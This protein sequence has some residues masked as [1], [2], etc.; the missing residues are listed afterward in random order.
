MATTGRARKMASTARRSSPSSRR[1]LRVSRAPGRVRSLSPPG[2]TL[3]QSGLRG[4]PSEVDPR[5]P[6]PGCV[7]HRCGRRGRAVGT[8]RPDGVRAWP[9]SGRSGRRFQNRAAPGPATAPMTTPRTGWRPTWQRRRPA[10]LCSRA[11]SCSEGAG[12][13]SPITR[14][15]LARPADFR[16]S[17]RKRTT[18]RSRRSLAGP[19]NASE[20]VDFRRWRP[21]SAGIAESLLRVLRGRTASDASCCP[22]RGPRPPSTVRSGSAATTRRERPTRSR[23]PSARLLQSPSNVHE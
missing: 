10:S 22:R 8:L 6:A 16:Q 4:R 7:R 9:S 20:R 14:Q 2:A 11:R 18:T 23:R 21:N 5:C 1:W 17:H 13:R 19:Q 12:A 3:C 15:K